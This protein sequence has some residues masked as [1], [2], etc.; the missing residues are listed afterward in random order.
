LELHVVHVITAEYYSFSKERADDAPQ[1]H[2]AVLGVLFKVDDDAPPHPFIEALKLDE[3]G[4]GSKIKLNMADYFGHLNSPEFFTYAGS[5]TTPPCSEIVNWYVV[6]QPE[7]I[8]SEQLKQF[9]GRSE[10]FRKGNNRYCQPIGSRRVCLGNC[11]YDF[12][13]ANAIGRTM[14]LVCTYLCY[15]F[16]S[17]ILYDLLN[18]L[19]YRLRNPVDLKR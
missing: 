10:S 1:R 2:L 19:C 9:S 7:T 3:V 15:L 4:N 17:F 6:S 18:F 12:S 13:C 5:L 11:H 14:N 16:R 8:T